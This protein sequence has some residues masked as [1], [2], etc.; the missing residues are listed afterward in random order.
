MAKTHPEIARQQAREKLPLD[1]RQVLAL[2]DI[3]KSLAAL[4]QEMKQMQ[5]LVNQIAQGIHSMR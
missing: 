3:A 2:E 1:A 5:A 4:T